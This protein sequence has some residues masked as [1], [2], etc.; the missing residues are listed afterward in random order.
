MPVRQNPMGQMAV[1]A[2][3][4]GLTAATEARKHPGVLV[5]VGLLALA[6]AAV[7]FGR[8]RIGRAAAKAAADARPK[9]ARAVR[10]AVMGAVRRRPLQVAKLVAQHPREALKL[11]KALR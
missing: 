10:P 6:G 9:I 3:G 4:K 8:G 11:A 5:G 1:A 7:W 2:K